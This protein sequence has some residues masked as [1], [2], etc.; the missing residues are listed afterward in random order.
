MAFDPSPQ[1]LLVEHVAARSLL[2]RLVRRLLVA[3]RT[4]RRTRRD[5]A[6]LLRVTPTHIQTLERR[7]FAGVTLGGRLGALHLGRLGRLRLYMCAADTTLARQTHM[8]APSAVPV[9]RRAPHL[10]HRRRDPPRRKKP[11]RKPRAQLPKLVTH[12]KG[13]GAPQALELGQQ[14]IDAGGSGIGHCS[15][16]V[17][18]CD[19]YTWTRVWRCGQNLI[20]LHVIH[21]LR[22]FVIVAVNR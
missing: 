14:V 8:L 2:A 9:H 5:E 13:N 7:A 6:L 16:F 17:C 18:L 12:L 20:F 15:V 1:T 4:L 22:E 3:D 10:H 11:S 21:T 19:N